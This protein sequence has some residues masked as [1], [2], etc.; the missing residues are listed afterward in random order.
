MSVKFV[1]PTGEKGE[2]T[3]LKDGNPVKVDEAVI[4]ELLK[5]EDIKLVLDLNVGSEECTYWTCDLSREY[6]SR[7][8]LT[9]DP[10]C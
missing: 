10:S 2:V 7:S 4:G 9:T 5:E 8:M 1:D 6:I 3:V